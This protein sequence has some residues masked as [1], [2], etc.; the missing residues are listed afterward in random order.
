MTWIFTRL[1]TNQHI[2]I[3]RDMVVGRH[4]NA[5]IVLDKQEVS[6]QHAGI[7]L[8]DAGIYI[9]DLNSSN[10]TFVNGEQISGEYQL[11]HGD[12]VR[13]ADIEFKI[14]QQ[15]DNAETNTESDTKNA[16][17]MS[18][19]GMLSLNERAKDIQVN[20]EGMPQNMSIPKPAPIPE[21]VD[22]NQPQAVAISEQ[23]HPPSDLEQ[24][25]EQQKSAY[26]GLIS[27]IIL[28]MIIVAVA[29]VVL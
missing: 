13:F 22:V 17:D 2:V 8:N 3:E 24:E 21:G 12:H 7:G 26:V 23:D 15:D 16:Q 4:A 27:L 28:V 5:D 6:R 18:E 9:V 14:S 1:D 10:G 20:R 29:I 25:K 19:Q 11:K